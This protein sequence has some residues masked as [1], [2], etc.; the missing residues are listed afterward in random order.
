MGYLMPE[1]SFS[2][3]SRCGIE[4]VVVGRDKRVHTF[5]WGKS[6]KVNVIANSFF[7]D[8]AI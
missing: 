1:S 5:P 2:K 7:Y 6:L 8:V 4:S 3:N